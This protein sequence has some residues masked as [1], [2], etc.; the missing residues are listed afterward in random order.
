MFAEEP[1]TIIHARSEEWQKKQDDKGRMGKSRAAKAGK[2][3]DAL[4]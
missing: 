2:E 1:L 3:L 4:G